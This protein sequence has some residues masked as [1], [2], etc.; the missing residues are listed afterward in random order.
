MTTVLFVETLNNGHLNDVTTGHVAESDAT[1]GRL[2][3]SS[4]LT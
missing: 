3:I 1:R 2:G 4:H